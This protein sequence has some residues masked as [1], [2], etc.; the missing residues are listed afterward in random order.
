MPVTVVEDW[1]NACSG[2]EISI[3]NVGDRLL[4]LLPELNFVH[5]TALVDHKFFGQLG[6]GTAMD[7]PES[8][9][10]IV[11]GGV[12]NEEMKH[13]LEEIRKKTKFLIALGSCACFGG[14]PAQANMWKNEDTFDKVFRHCVT[15]DARSQPGRPQCA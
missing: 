5:M 14:V 6:D 8:V 2:C 1:L 13:E 3:L 10:A 15:T 7:I 12:R 4:D 11:S 9:V